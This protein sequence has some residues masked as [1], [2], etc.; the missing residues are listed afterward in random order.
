M[1]NKLVIFDVSPFIYSAMGIDKYRND[2]LYDFPVGGIKNLLKHV[3]FV[4]RSYG[5]VVLCFDSRSFRKDINPA[6]KAGRQKNPLVYAQLDLLYEVLPKC[7][8]VCLKEEGLEA[9]DLI[10]NVVE[11]N[12]SEY[13]V[14]EIM[15][16][17]YD[18]THNVAYTNVLFRSITTQVHSVSPSN[19]TTAIIPGKKLLYNTIAAYKVFCGDNSDS[20][21]E[22]KG[23]NPNIT[24]E[25][26]YNKYIKLI[27]NLN[28]EPKV[29]RSRALL[30]KFIAKCGNVL[31]DVDRMKLKINMDL[32]Y[33]R[34][35]QGD[36]K[37]VTIRKGMNLA[38]LQSV[39]STFEDKVS[40]KSLDLKINSIDT[41]IVNK[42]KIMA[43][44]LKTGEYS[45]DNNRPFRD[46]GINT[47]VVNLKEF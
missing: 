2:T 37:Q 40:L 14:I 24:G 10:Y 28:L 35:I 46:V 3:S 16:T 4:L 18:L 12:Q 5:D 30:E 33:P 23:T 13:L 45:I 1:R 15:G 41:T 6:Y 8:I 19:F 43:Q 42:M 11:A 26:L 44:G 27:S 31:T 36:F 17:D 22:F 9:D 20:I 38:P 29:L 47:E 21:A 32:V 25:L 7:G 39:L 34:V